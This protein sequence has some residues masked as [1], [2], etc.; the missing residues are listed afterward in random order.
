MELFSGQETITFI[1]T[2][3][4]PKSKSK[5]DFINEFANDRTVL[6]GDLNAKHSNWGC[7]KTNKKSLIL[8]DKLTKKINLEPTF[9]KKKENP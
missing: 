9:E 8:N 2:F 6:I 7:P 4:H 3:V 1:A 5:F